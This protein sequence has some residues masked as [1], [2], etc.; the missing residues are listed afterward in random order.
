MC[1]SQ[2]RSMKIALVRKERSPKSTWCHFYQCPELSE[3]WSKK[4]QSCNINEH[5]DT[6]SDVVREGSHAAYG[7]NKGTVCNAVTAKPSQSAY[8]W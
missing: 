7:A 5:L 8:S 1:T 6:S 3:T 2:S 4:L